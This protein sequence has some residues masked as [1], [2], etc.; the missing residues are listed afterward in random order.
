MRGRRPNNVM[1]LT[2][3]SMDERPCEQDRRVTHHTAS[4]RSVGYIGI[5]LCRVYRATPHD[6][7]GLLRALGAPIR[8]EWRPTATLLQR[9]DHRSLVRVP[10]MR[11]PERL[12]H[13]HV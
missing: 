12:H 9:S 1:Q 4:L 11:T 5:R 3:G 10:S 13:A 6:L 2:R 8:V 7:R